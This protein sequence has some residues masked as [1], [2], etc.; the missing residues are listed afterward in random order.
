MRVLLD[1]NILL[2]ALLPST[3]PARAV[4]LILEAGHASRFRLLVTPELLAE[5]TDK[6]ESKPSLTVRIGREHAQFRIDAD[7]LIESIYIGPGRSG[8]FVRLVK[9]TLE[10][11]GLPN[12]PVQRSGM[13]GKP[14]YLP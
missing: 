5:V 13:D 9:E 8:G 4:A 12:K 3:N 2:R 10:R 14:L 7:T 1:A 11:C 6:A